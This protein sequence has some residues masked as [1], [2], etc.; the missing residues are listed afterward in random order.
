M[1]TRSVASCLTSLV[2]A[3]SEELSLH[4]A[5]CRPVMPRHAAVSLR[6]LWSW[7]LC[8]ACS[9]QTQSLPRVTSSHLLPSSLNIHAAFLD[10]HIEHTILLVTG[11]ASIALLSPGTLEYLLESLVRTL[12]T[13]ALCATVHT[14]FHNTFLQTLN[15]FKNNA[16]CHNRLFITSLTL[17]LE[18]VC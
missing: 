9:K 11:P 7:R 18:E 1:N 2:L 16:W 6:G 3:C 17:K 8:W 15:L 14:L 4:N 12:R 5:N 10:Q 13:T